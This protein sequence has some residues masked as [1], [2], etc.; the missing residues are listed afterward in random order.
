MALT[1]VSHYG[2]TD[3]RL[4]IN[5]G[6]TIDLDSG[7]D[8]T[9]I[10]R[11]D[12]AV[13]GGTITTTG[14]T[15]NLASTATTISIGA[16]TGT[17]TINNDHVVVDSTAALQIPAG[18]TSDRPTPITGQIRYNTTTNQ[19]EGYG[20]STWRALDVLAN[21]DTE[22]AFIAAD[23]SS[24]STKSIARVAGNIHIKVTGATAGTAGSIKD[25]WEPFVFDTVTDLLAS[26]QSSRG[27]NSMWN[28]GN[29]SYVETSDVTPDITNA[30]GVPLNVHLGGVQEIHGSA[31]M[32]TD[33][34]TDQFTQFNKAIQKCS[35]AK[36]R[37]NIEGL[38]IAIG[39]Q[40][41]TNNVYNDISVGSPNFPTTRTYAIL[42][43]VSGFVSLQGKGTVKNLN[44][45]DDQYI[46]HSA[47]S[48]YVEIGDHVTL[49]G[50]H[51]EH[52]WGGCLHLMG[53][54]HLHLGR[55]T[56]T[57][58]GIC[59]VGASQTKR[60]KLITFTHPQWIDC[61]GT[62]CIGGKPGGFEEIKGDTLYFE[63]VRGGLNL[64]TEDVNGLNDD[65]ASGRLWDTK[66][67]G[68]INAVYAKN[69]NGV[70]D[71]TFVAPASVVVC[72]D[73]EDSNISIGLIHAVDVTS[74]VNA[75]CLLVGGGQSD[76]PYSTVKVER[77]HGI[78][79]YSAFRYDGTDTGGEH[80]HIGSITGDGLS[81]NY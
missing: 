35:A 6:G 20:G 79:V 26:R 69:V 78:N 45:N 44:E 49:N 51:T 55:C 29:F 2:V 8:G 14:S 80:V 28:A 77:I 19:F 17:L 70:K 9:V 59:R 71:P 23:T 42:I 1:K 10:V 67:I 65:G 56:F 36:V 60:S 54:E 40:E 81:S 16:A 22:A 63:N 30:A 43:P 34:T 39:K 66:I 27:P 73:A 62:H 74:T 7:S 68:T 18:T 25:G 4:K 64:E 12:L 53:L 47:D 37:L 38:T 75:E 41:N 24:L 11:G 58:D 57:Q 61:W 13:N 5:P 46:F 52:G 72:T 33:S 15:L 48:S 76:M 3:Y 21:F 31:F 50:N 32:L